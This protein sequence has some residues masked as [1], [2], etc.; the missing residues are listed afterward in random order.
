MAENLQVTW[1]WYALSAR[2]N[3]ILQKQTLFVFTEIWSRDQ[4]MQKA[5]SLQ[6]PTWV[7][8]LYFGAPV[9]V[10]LFITC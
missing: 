3:K 5:Y 2:A 6:E 1:F 4:L 10:T 7:V 8:G 9:N